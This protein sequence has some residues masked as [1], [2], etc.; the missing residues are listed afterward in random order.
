VSQWSAT[1]NEMVQTLVWKSKCIQQD[2]GMT[3]QLSYT[4]LGFTQELAV[5]QCL[6]VHK[7]RQIDFGLY[8]DDIEA[9]ADEEQLD[10]L[11]ARFEERYEIKWLGF[12]SKNDSESSEKT[13]EK[14]SEKSQVK[15]AKHL[16]EFEPKLIM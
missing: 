8:V 14:T 1:G 7:E 4:K 11:R 12:N 2:P 5:D 10:W 6:F 15:R 13:S 16:L 3:W 9:S